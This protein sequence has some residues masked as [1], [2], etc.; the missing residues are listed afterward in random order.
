MKA[1]SEVH[2]RSFHIYHVI[3]VFLLANA[4]GSEP[5]FLSSFHFVSSV[6]VVL[7]FAIFL[8]LSTTGKNSPLQKI[9]FMSGSVGLTVLTLI[10]LLPHPTLAVLIS[11]IFCMIVIPKQN[12]P[13]SYKR[14]FLTSDT[15]LVI[16]LG[17]STDSGGLSIQ[18]VPM[19]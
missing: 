7:G 11:A 10:R 13:F 17:L 12:Q 18:T 1:T 6:W 19:K 8:F 5:E 16:S 9:C 3:P 14:M 4:G 15:S 2:P